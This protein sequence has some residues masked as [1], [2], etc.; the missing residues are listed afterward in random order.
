M[1]LMDNFMHRNF[2][3]TL[4]FV[5]L[6]GISYS[7][8]SA[9]ATVSA[10]ISYVYR[11]KINGCNFKPQDRQQTGFRVQ[12][13]TGIITALHGVAD[14]K[15]VSALSDDGKEIYNDLLI[16]QV[17][18]ERDVALLSSPTI[19]KSSKVGLLPSGLSFVEIKNAALQI[20]GYPLGAEKQDV[21]KIEHI[22]DIES[23]DDV[24]PDAEE[25]AD[26]IKRKSPSLEITVLNVQAQLLPGHSGAPILDSK[27]QVVAI[28]NGGLRSGTVGRS[29]AIPWIEVKLQPV[30]RAEIRAKLAEL[31]SKD[32]AALTFS[33]TFPATPVRITITGVGF[34]RSNESNAARRNQS[35]LL[36][37]QKDANRNFILWRDGADLAAVTIVE[38]GEVT[39]DTIRVEIKKTRVRSGKILEQSYDDTT[40]MAQVTVEYIVTVT[41]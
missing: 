37:A 40:G 4:T 2:L 15:S 33:S 39:T 41:E 25:P 12:G 13:I 21:D 26:F 17:D 34:A 22:R 6:L 24:I 7:S 10:P 28:G 5:L 18:I 14:C 3:G 30:T 27:N 20:A 29:W 32:I 31:A 11:I 35:A 38:Q 23:L 19:E 8:V 36:A 1:L 9:A 16:R